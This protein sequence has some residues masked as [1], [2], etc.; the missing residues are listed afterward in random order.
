[1][2]E[3]EKSK[4]FQYAILLHPLAEKADETPAP[5]ELLVGPVTVLA[6]SEEKALILAAREI[7]SG[8]LKRLDEV[9]IA[10]RPF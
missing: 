6:T 8:Y 2:A 5:S 4:L 3:R 9:E 10:V 1:M 7:P